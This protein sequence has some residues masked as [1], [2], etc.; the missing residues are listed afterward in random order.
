MEKENDGLSPQPQSEASRIPRRRV[1][2]VGA[3][4]LAGEFAVMLGVA[5]LGDII[6]KSLR[7]RSQ[8]NAEN[9]IVADLNATATA[10]AKQG[11]IDTFQPEGEFTQEL[12]YQ[13]RDATF[14]TKVEFNGEAFRATTWVIHQKPS[15]KKEGYSDYVLASAGHLLTGGGTRKPS[16]IKTVEIALPYNSSFHEDEKNLSFALDPRAGNEAIGDEGVI[17]ITEPDILGIRPRFRALAYQDNYI[18]KPNERMLLCGFPV[19][20]M[21]QQLINSLA[22]G[23]VAN[24]QNINSS[25]GV[26]TIKAESDHGMSGG[27]VSIV[28]NGVP[29]V[30]G[31]L[32]QG[33]GSELTVTPLNMT[34]LIKRVS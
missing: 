9:R 12:F 19:E 24:V 6:G 32:V 20:F 7:S 10:A 22:Q 25:T 21:G 23:V 3:A 14:A 31:I 2:T 11:R 13:V 34:P 29:V 26:W 8:G 5:K 28:R 27:S 17:R 15:N 16:D 1:V 18:P 33:N 30:V 4:L